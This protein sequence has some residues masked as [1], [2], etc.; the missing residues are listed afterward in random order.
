MLFISCKIIVFKLKSK[1]FCKSKWSADNA[2]ILYHL[3]IYV[4]VT[5][6]VC[7]SNAINLEIITFFMDP[8]HPFM[9]PCHPGRHIGI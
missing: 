2:F 5:F 1:P 6:I 4:L 9:H 3:F 7:I 8:R